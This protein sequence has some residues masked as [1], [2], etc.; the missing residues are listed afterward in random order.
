MAMSAMYAERFIC[1][2]DLLNMV[3]HARIAS[4]LKPVWL[5]NSGIVCKWLATNA[6]FNFLLHSGDKRCVL[7][8]TLQPDDASLGRSLR[9]LLVLRMSQFA[10]TKILYIPFY[11]FPQCRM[12][13]KLIAFFSEQL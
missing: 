6:I 8:M 10:E 2:I 11:R 3:S 12:T 7:R 13:S 1:G 9:S 5:T 4:F